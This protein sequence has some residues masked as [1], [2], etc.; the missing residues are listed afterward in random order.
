MGFA[1]LNPTYA[2]E[3]NSGRSLR[4]WKTPCVRKKIASER[5]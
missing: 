5:R 2:A 1:A 4:A 3:R